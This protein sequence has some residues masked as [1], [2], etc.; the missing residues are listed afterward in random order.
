MVVLWVMVGEEVNEMQLAGW[1]GT[2]PIPG[3]NLPGWTGTWFSIFPNVETFAAQ[4]LA[5]GGSWSAPTS[6]RSMCASGV[7][8]GAVKRAPARRRARPSQSAPSALR[9][10]RPHPSEV[11]SADEEAERARGPMRRGE[12]QPVAPA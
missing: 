8:D 9:P 5:R 2:T 3:L 7:R 1:I 11:R 4:A 10:L 6:R 12:R